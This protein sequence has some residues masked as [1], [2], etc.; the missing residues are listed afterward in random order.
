MENNLG[1]KIPEN[2]DKG[3]LFPLLGPDKKNYTP[4]EYI[5]KLIK[6]E[7]KCE[8][9]LIETLSRLSIHAMVK[10]ERYSLPYQ[11]EVSHSLFGESYLNGPY[12]FHRVARV[13]AKEL[14]NSDVYKIRFYIKIDVITEGS[15]QEIGLMGKIQYNLRYYIH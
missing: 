8:K 5:S 10:T 14:L 6:F 13:F 9:S 2:L 15:F 7:E 3:I 11:H 1:R 12:E 4:Q